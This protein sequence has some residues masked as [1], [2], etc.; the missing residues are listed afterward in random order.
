[1]TI[2]TGITIENQVNLTNQTRLP[3][4]TVVFFYSAGK[5][6]PFLT[7]R[8]SLPAQQRRYSE[9]SEEFSCL[10]RTKTKS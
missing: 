8:K 2:A 5:D 6:K 10:I 9:R 7:A 1:M 4:S 3:L